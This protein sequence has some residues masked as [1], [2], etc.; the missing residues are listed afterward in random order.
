VPVEPRP[1]IERYE[2]L[3]AA[4]LEAAA[5]SFRHGLA[6]LLGKGVVAWMQ[7][8]AHAAPEPADGETAGA[9]ANGALEGVEREL[10]RVLAGIA[11]QAVQ[12]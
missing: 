11:L 4:A 1:L 5:D 3:R 9:P 7:V 8:A 2:A 12:G 6:L 10:V